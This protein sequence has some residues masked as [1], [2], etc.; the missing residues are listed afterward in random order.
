MKKKSKKS[1]LIILGIV[2]LLPC[3]IIGILNYLILYLKYIRRKNTIRIIDIKN[4]CTP[5][6]FACSVVLPIN[7]ICCYYV[8]ELFFEKIMYDNLV[9]NS[10]EIM[11][12]C[13]TIF[14]LI[15]SIIIIGMNMSVVYFGIVFDLDQKI[16]ICPHDM[17]SYKIL[18]YII[19]K[20]I[21]NY[22]SVDIINIYDINK[23]SRGYG[24]ELYLHGKFG[25]RRIKMSSKQKRDECIST[26]QNI[27]KQKGMML[28]EIESY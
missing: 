15:I 4:M 19:L 14:I 12:I 23:I 26:I 16:I 18:D 1:N 20:F 7:V 11:I 21:F 5:I 22:A 27:I 10:Y 25:S 3:L 8:Y 13:I 28:C 2:C 9:M 6:M 17:Q 24:K